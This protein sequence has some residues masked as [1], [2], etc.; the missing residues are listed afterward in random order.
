MA[1]FQLPTEYPLLFGVNYGKYRIMKYTIAN[2]HRSIKGERLE[3]SDTS[4]ASMV[5]PPPTLKA[6]W[7]EQ[8]TSSGWSQLVWRTCWGYSGGDSVQAAVWPS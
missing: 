1:I 5:F 3:Q 7:R 2:L 8:P 6:E 4:S